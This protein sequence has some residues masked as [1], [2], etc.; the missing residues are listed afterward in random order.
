MIKVDHLNFHLVVNSLS[1]KNM[2][3][4][5][6]NTTYCFFTKLLLLQKLD[7]KFLQINSLQK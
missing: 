1:I 3:K 7:I 4:V 6:K 2:K 5:L